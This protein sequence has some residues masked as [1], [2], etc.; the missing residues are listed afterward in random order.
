MLFLSRIM[1]YKATIFLKCASHSFILMNLITHH[2]QQIKS[3]ASQESGG[4]HGTCLYRKGIHFFSFQENSSLDFD[5]LTVLLEYFYPAPGKEAWKTSLQVHLCQIILIFNLFTCR[6]LSLA[7]QA[8]P[9]DHTQPFSHQEATSKRIWQTREK[10]L[11]ILLMTTRERR[12]LSFSLPAAEL[13]FYRKDETKAWKCADAA[14]L[15]G[16]IRMVESLIKR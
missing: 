13:Q 12:V 2:T 16:V 6:L 7:S 8:R 4:D 10:G 11:F 5:E 3:T 14:S 9:Q 1:I 15:R